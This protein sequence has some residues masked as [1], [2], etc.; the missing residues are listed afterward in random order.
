M[1][2][3]F[4]NSMV[5]HV[6]AQGEQAYGHSHNGN[7]YFDG[8]VLYSYGSHFAVGVRMNDNQAVLNSDSYSI[9]TSG[10][11]SD[12]SSAVSHFA[13]VYVP[14]LQDIARELS[15]I[16]NNGAKKSPRHV[17]AVIAHIETH[18][19]AMSLK[20]G[21]YSW[22]EEAA[23]E[24]EETRADR[25]LRFCGIPKARASAA[26]KRGLAKAAKK[27]KADAAQSRKAWKAEAVKIADMTPNEFDGHLD[28]RFHVRPFTGR[29]RGDEY[30][31]ERLRNASKELFRLIKTAKAEKLSA[32][33]LGRLK[34]HR[35][36][37]L[38]TL[39]AYNDDRAAYHAE[40]FANWEARYSA[41][42]DDAERLAVWKTNGVKAADYAEGTP[43]RAKLE[44]ADVEGRALYDAERMAA[45]REAREAWLKGENSGRYTRLSGPGVP[46]LVRRS[47]DGERL[48]TSH[49]A[50][51]PWSHAVKAFR[52]VRLCVE[53]GEAFH[54]NGRV[55]RVGHFT[56][57]YITA[58][59]DM[60]AGCHRFA[61]ADMKALAEREGV[62]ALSPS[63]EAVEQR[64]GVAH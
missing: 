16:A 24:G 50:D 26:I 3:V 23:T 42:K 1:A 57:D 25:L 63:A 61:W 7:F 55:I 43:E 30:A 11:Q 10:M 15:Y 41:A 53:K 33:R 6:W 18:A 48:E 19:A 39:K 46:A 27:A 8:R 38:A 21:S 36:G 54:T 45:E 34:A 31:A 37:I 14:K 22:Q 5:A 17:A 2:K 56:V 40:R 20:A 58:D 28:R 52:F 12:A 59:G 51:V 47:S 44:A 29:A 49:G 62:F 35:A 60:K 64:E 4:N 13:T 32:A 9:S